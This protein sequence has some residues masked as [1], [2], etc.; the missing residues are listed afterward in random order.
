MNFVKSCG[1]VA[2]RRV[3]NENLY[4]IITSKNGDVGFPKGHMEENETELQ[5]AIRELKEETN[6]DVT[7]IPGFR[8]EINYLLPNRKDTRKISVY[9]LGE[10]I[11]NHL[12]PQEA[13]V[14]KAEFLPYAEAREAL[15]FSDTKT[16]L[17]EAEEHINSIF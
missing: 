9:F 6:T 14:N 17:A 13:E 3:N 16:I 1:F 15:T 10:S 12:V 7:P 11:S 8:R 5:T 2:F 4:L